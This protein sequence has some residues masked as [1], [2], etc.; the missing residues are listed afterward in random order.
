M[1]EKGDLVEVIGKKYSNPDWDWAYS[2]LVK[3]ALLQG[4]GRGRSITPEAIPVVLISTEQLDLIISADN[5]TE[6]S[7]EEDTTLHIV[8][9][10]TSTSTSGS[11]DV[12][13]DS[14]DRIPNR[15]ILRD[16][17]LDFFSSKE[18]NKHF[19]KESLRNVQRRLAKLVKI[20]LL[21]RTKDRKGFT[22]N[23]QNLK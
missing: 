17:S 1:N 15:S 3:E 4:I 2:L 10:A 21:V 20:G 23:C 13:I 8:L 9:S 18:L 22:V 6:I 16:L 11:E 12:T 14:S 5:F 7:D 19:P